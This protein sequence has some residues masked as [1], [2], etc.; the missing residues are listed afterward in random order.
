MTEIRKRWAENGSPQ[1]QPFTSRPRQLSGGWLIG[2]VRLSSDEI[3]DAAGLHNSAGT[4]RIM[5]LSTVRRA[6]CGESAGG[7]SPGIAPLGQA[8]VSPARSGT[9][10]IFM[11]I[12]P[13]FALKQATLQTPSGV[14]APTHR[15]HRIRSQSREF[16]S[17]KPA[18]ATLRPVLASDRFA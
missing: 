11:G 13:Q 9:C 5:S 7:A 16:Y 18:G 4:W 3:G 6:G 12:S 15:F 2:Q 8:D 14:Y 10:Q 17:D 1:G